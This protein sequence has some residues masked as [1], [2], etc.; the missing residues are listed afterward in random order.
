[1][2][3]YFKKSMDFKPITFT[4]AGWFYIIV[5]IVL[6]FAAVNTGN[7]LIFIIVSFLLAMMAVSGFYGKRNINNIRINFRLPAEIY[8]GS[9]CLMKLKADNT[10]HFLDSYFLKIVLEKS[11]TFFD[12]IRRQGRK[13]GKISL[14]FEKRGINHIDGILLYSRFPFNFFIRCK[15]V[16]VNEEVLVFPKPVK[17][18]QILRN[19][20]LNEVEGSEVKDNFASEELSSL[21][22]YE[23]G[24]SFRLIHWKHFAKSDELKTKNFSGGLNSPVIID[25]SNLESITENIISAVTYDIIDMTGNNI[26]VGLKTGSDY[27]PPGTT[28]HHKLNLLRYLALYDEN[29]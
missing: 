3:N 18:R 13:E 9:P 12:K 14:T 10:K 27:F 5:T 28:T 15:K 1:M 21:K 7:N 17:T 4:K 19:Y 8:A 23:Y 6:G 26:P 2:K 25:I 22:N 29:K 11:E 24:D 20:L 16:P